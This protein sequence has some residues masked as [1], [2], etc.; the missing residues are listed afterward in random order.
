M[1]NPGDEWAAGD[2]PEPPPD[3]QDFHECPRCGLSHC[4]P[5]ELCAV[6]LKQNTDRYGEYGND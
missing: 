1:P 5:Q 4:G 2:I 6:C 3:P